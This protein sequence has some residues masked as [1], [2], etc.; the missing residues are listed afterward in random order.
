MKYLLALV[1][2]LLSCTARTTNLHVAHPPPHST[3]PFET[4]LVV[5]PF[6]APQCAWWAA[7]QAWSLL[8]PSAVLELRLGVESATTGPLGSTVTVT[9]GAPPDP[10]AKALTAAWRRGEEPQAH[11]VSANIWIQD[12]DVRLFAHELGHVLGLR[13][14]DAPGSIMHWRYSDGGWSL[15]R[16][17]RAHLKG[18]ETH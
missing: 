1:A 9:W 4:V 2:L 6:D 18:R 12:C 17:E 13:D 16:A 8:D 7:E 15:S 5:I 3:W 10:S 11:T 14:R